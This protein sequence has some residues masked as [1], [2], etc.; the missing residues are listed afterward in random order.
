MFAKSVCP[1]K[2]FKA[3]KMK[4]FI[5]L[6]IASLVNFSCSSKDEEVQVADSENRQESHYY[7]INGE[8]AEAFYNKF[9][10]S[11]DATGSYRYHFVKS[12]WKHVGEETATDANRIC[13]TFDLFLLESKSAVLDYYERPCLIRSD[14]PTSKTP[15][16]SKRYS[17]EWKVEGTKLLIGKIAFG[18][19][20]SLNGR[21]TISVQ[22]GKDIN[23]FGLTNFV[24]EAYRAESS[25]GI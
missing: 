10:Y 6:A 12:S 20:Y 18:E 23:R 22:F 21:P 9:L 25:T 8:T 7:E 16:F 24:F 19:G 2:H 15:V 4:C 1:E 17:D 11:V 3:S 5:V 13:A 14:V